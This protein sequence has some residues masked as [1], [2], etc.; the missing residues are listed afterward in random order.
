MINIGYPYY[1]FGSPNSVDVDVMIDHPEASSRESDSMIAH[2]LKH[3]YP[4]T[5][6]WNMNII[7]ISGGIVVDSIPNKGSADSANNSLYQTFQY[8]DQSFA[9]PID[10]LVVRNLPLAVVKCVNASILWFKDTDMHHEYK[11]R[12]RPALMS[13][14]WADSVD[15]LPTL[16]FEKP[17]TDD[18]ITNGN[19]YK[20]LAF[21]IGQTV[22]LFC[23]VEVYTKGELGNFYPE[24]NPLLM[25][26]N[27][28]PHVILNR[29][30]SE[31]NRLISAE[32]II[33]SSSH[34]IEWDDKL[35][36]T[37]RCR[38]IES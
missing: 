4:E 16:N 34:L 7:R 9:F 6:S 32:N 25:R 14:K 15:L 37:R 21:N 28:N 35:I 2:A 18:M 17:F 8:H 13:G 3:N 29:K 27:I 23:G 38:L 10:R 30:L 5:E 19:I 36:D 20:S 33:Q 31:L 11:E 22:A 24:I 12:L 1:F 26:E